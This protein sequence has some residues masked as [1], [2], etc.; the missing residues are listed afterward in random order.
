MQWS[1]S[2]GQSAM[3][4]YRSV[5]SELSLPNPC[6]IVKV[7]AGH[8]GL[9]CVLLSDMGSAY[10]L[11]VSRRGEDGD[12]GRYRK[13]P[14]VLKPKRITKT[15]GQFIVDVACNNGTTA[16]VTKDGLLYMFGKDVTYCESLTGKY[17][18]KK[19]N[20]IIYLMIILYLKVL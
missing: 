9:H 10:F 14:R 20:L 6:K 16:L 8:D 17:F 1:K 15:D 4:C 3:N 12:Q 18:N 7:A 11:G 5:W 19:F 13:Q 2:N